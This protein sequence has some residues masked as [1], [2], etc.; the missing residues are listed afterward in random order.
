MIKII[1]IPFDSANKCFLEEELN[2]FKASLFRHF[3]QYMNGETDEDHAAA[4]LFNVQGIEY[5][6]WKIENAHT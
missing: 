3:I 1:T 2:R 6:K 4:I 5:V